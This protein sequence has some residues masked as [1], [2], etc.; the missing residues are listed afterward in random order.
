MDP[1]EVLFSDL[2]YSRDVVA[3]AISA[4]EQRLQEREAMPFVVLFVLFVG[5]L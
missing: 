4:A 3:K 2:D 1:G 5:C